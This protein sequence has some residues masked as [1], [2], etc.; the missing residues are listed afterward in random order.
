M[1][2]SLLIGRFWGTEI[3]LHGSLLLLIPY[4]LAAFQPEDAAGALRVLLL[5][6][7]LFVC[8]ALHEIGHTIAARLF[9]IQVTSIVLWPLGGVANL[10]RRPEKVLPDL[11]ISAAGPL[12]NLL[13]FIFLAVITAAVRIVEFSGAFPALTRLL[14]ALDAFPFLLSLAIANLV[15]ALFNL[16]PIYPLDGGHIARGILKSIF[17][18]KR[19][20]MILLL[21]SLPLALAL[22]IAGI[23]AHDAIIVLTGIL[24]VLGGLTLNTQLL[25]GMLLGGL[26]FMDRGGYYLKRSDFDPALRE[27]NRAIQRSP[28]RAGL[29]I[30][31]AVVFMNLFEVERALSD[32][33]R[34]LAL[35]PDNHL[36]WTLCGELHT[37]EKKYD[38]ALECFN[39]AIQ[40]QPDW[41][42]AY[43]DRGGLYQEMGNFECVLQDLNHSVETGRG[44]PVAYLVR[45]NLR[46]QMGDRQ[47]ARSDADQCLRYAPQWMLV[48]PEIFLASMVGHFDWAQAYYRMAVDRFPKAYQSYQGRADAA[49]VNQHPAWAIEDYTRA[50]RLAPRTAELYLNRGRAHQQIGALD[51]AVEDFQQSLHLEKKSHLKRQAQIYL[52]GI[53]TGAPVRSL[54]FAEASGAAP[55]PGGPTAPPEESA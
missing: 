16:V 40:L 52:D 41:S 43:V 38:K 7:A 45:S 24:L 42:N 1:K 10:S 11:L 6:T 54:P 46:F 13:L 28:N 9:S 22:V 32:I 18:E 30:S 19:A 25:N 55:V 33:E 36:A 8:V 48:F 51:K 20:D 12:T 14:S 31:R 23:A 17:G 44:S 37:L 21:L 3:R 26:F 39:R 5:I 4:G 47:G 50:I 15:L 29:Y 35:A 2:W 27:Y 53:T 49:L 34:A